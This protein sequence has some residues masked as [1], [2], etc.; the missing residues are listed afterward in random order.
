MQGKAAGLP[1]PAPGAYQADGVLHHLVRHLLRIHA[2]GPFLHLLP[3]Q[4]DPFPA[5]GAPPSP[6]PPPPPFSA[7]APACCPSSPGRIFTSTLPAPDPRR[8]GRSTSTTSTSSSR[9]SSCREWTDSRSSPTRKR[10][11]ATA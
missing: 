8:L 10:P 3:E 9:T 1:R 11:S 6:A 2:V 5:G 7:P 4:V